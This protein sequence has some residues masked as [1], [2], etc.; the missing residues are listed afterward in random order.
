MA[1]TYPGFYFISVYMQKSYIQDTKNIT[2]SLINNN[3]LSILF[4]IF[5]SLI[6]K[7]KRYPRG[8]RIL[9]NLEEIFAN[10]SNIYS[11]KFPCIKEIKKSSCIET[12]ESKEF[13]TKNFNKE[14]YP[15]LIINPVFNK[16]FEN[17]NVNCVDTEE[18]LNDLFISSKINLGL[19]KEI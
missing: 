19:V 5:Y 9:F 15:I 6:L 18:E 2:L 4:L 3:C 1:L 17:Y 16:E 8:Y 12:T 14:N 11:C 13:L 10:S 7:P